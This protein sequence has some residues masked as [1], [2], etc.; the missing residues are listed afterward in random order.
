MTA[1]YCDGVSPIACA[2]SRED[3]ELLVAERVRKGSLLVGHFELVFI[4]GLRTHVAHPEAALKGAAML[5]ALS[6]T[7]LQVERS[8]LALHAMLLWQKGAGLLLQ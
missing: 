8:V 3:L 2:F 4:G 7:R 1:L 6:S 5:L